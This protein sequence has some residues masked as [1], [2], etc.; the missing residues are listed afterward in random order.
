MQR[1]VII[2]APFYLLHSRPEKVVAERQDLLSKLQQA[3]EQLGLIPNA[4]QNVR[5]GFMQDAQEAVSRI[6]PGSMEQTS[7]R[8]TGHEEAS[9]E[10][11]PIVDISP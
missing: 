2:N 3:L 1:N 8:L 7:N 4:S 11:C 6:L 10:A 5:Q 9:F